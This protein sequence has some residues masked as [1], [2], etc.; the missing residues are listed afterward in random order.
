M[1]S[2]VVFWVQLCCLSLHSFISENQNKTVIRTLS[3]SGDVC[4][5]KTKWT[6]PR[7]QLSSEWLHKQRRNLG[8]SN[9]AL[10][11][12]ARPGSIIRQL[13]QEDC[14]M[15]KESSF[16]TKNMTFE[17]AH[18]Q[19]SPSISTKT[20]Q[21]FAVVIAVRVYTGSVVCTAVQT[22]FTLVNICQQRRELIVREG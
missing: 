16:L 14:D 2:Q 8:H 6:I 7:K 10:L 1:S 4:A 3:S 20:R 19:A 18:T 9:F 21:T 12:V 13:W 11:L 17:Q 5:P 15:R 22:I